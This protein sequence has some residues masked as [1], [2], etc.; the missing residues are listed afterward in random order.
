[1]INTTTRETFPMKRISKLFVSALA[2]SVVASVLTVAT[3][4]SAAVTVTLG[5]SSSLIDGEKISVT[6]AGIP[7]GQGVYVQQC[8]QPKVGTRAATGL[9]C[10]GSLQQTDLMIWATMDSARGSQPATAPLTFTVR[11]NVTTSTE[12]LPCG[13]NDC[14][15]F[16]FRD[17]RGIS[18]TSLDTVVPL[19]FLGDQT[20]KLRAMGF[21]KPD[22]EQKVG[23]SLKLSSSLLRTDQ[24]GKVRVVSTNEEVCQVNNGGMTTT[25]RFAKRGRCSLQLIARSDSKYLRLTFDVAYRVR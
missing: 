18:D 7:A 24:K 22:S 12:T 11:R 23:A 3:P 2:A 25:V 17:H 13:M 8:Y 20:L 5:K 4:A 1:M 15:I 10:S 19:T 21:P 9:K 6:L 14:A 16:V